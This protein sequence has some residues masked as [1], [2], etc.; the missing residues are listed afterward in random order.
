MMGRI[1]IIYKIMPHDIGRE[2]VND[3][4]NKVS[5]LC[6]NMHIKLHDYKI[7]P[8]AFGLFSLKILVSIPEEK[9]DIMNILEENMRKLEGIKSI[10]V[11]GMSRG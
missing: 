1:N 10:E 4:V 7:E 11:V 6:N 9:G 5:E 2:A 3:I 8:V